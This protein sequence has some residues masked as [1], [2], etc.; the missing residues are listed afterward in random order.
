[1]NMMITNITMKCCY[2][3]ISYYILNAW[4]KTFF[5]IGLDR[6]YDMLSRKKC[7]VLETFVLFSPIIQLWYST[8]NV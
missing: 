2:L 5:N 8:D 4:I 7:D 6:E 1:M 3:Y